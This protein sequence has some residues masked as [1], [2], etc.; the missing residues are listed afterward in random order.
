MVDIS[1]LHLFYCN[2][3]HARCGV[4]LS[5]GWSVVHGVA[6]S[7]RLAEVSCTVWRLLIGWLKCRA[8]CGVFL[9]IGWSVVHGVASS[10]RLA[11]VSCTVW[12]LLIDWLK[13]RAR[14]GVFLSV[15]WSVVQH[16]HGSSFK[17]CAVSCIVW[18]FE[19]ALA[20]SNDSVCSSAVVRY[21]ESGEEQ[22]PRHAPDQ[23]RHSGQPRGGD[24]WRLPHL[25]T[26][27]AGEM[28]MGP[29]WWLCGA[30]EGVTLVFGWHWWLSDNGD[31]GD[32]VTVVIGWPGDGV[33]VVIR[34]PQ[35]WDDASDKVTPVMVW[36][37]W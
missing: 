37:W 3:C 10:Y 14:C 30:D 11:E 29:C 8:R 22:R 7:Y 24:D 20:A 13:C 28:V 12:R 32:G 6:S 33:T 27:D 31:P 21:W 5:I 25:W 2:C 18:S 34:W 9:S 35:W 26:G 19:R 16:V 36:Q 4:F 15:G 1:T 17:L 23:H